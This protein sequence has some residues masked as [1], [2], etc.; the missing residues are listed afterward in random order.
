MW[1]LPGK[2]LQHPTFGTLRPFRGGHFWR[3]RI[4]FPPTGKKV[5]LSIHAG[6]DG[7]TPAHEKIYNSLLSKYESIL[8]RLT[9]VLYLEYQKVRK[10]HAETDW[11]KVSEADLLNEIPLHRLWLEEGAGHP[12][13]LSFQSARDR[14]HE[15]HVFFRNGKLQNVSFER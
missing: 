3:G 13:V 9:H 2:K 10:A 14:D 11:P 15:F 5:W 4:V 1:F 8:P 6:D 12:F 7:P